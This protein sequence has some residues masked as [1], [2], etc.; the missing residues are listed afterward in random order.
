MRSGRAKEI[1]LKRSKTPRDALSQLSLSGCAS[2]LRLVARVAGR[3]RA[4]RF[5]PDDSFGFVRSTHRMLP[6][7]GAP[8]FDRLRNISSRRSFRVLVIT[9]VH[10]TLASRKSSLSWTLSLDEAVSI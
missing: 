6:A 3:W 4:S 2:V 8:E 9:A 1:V 10:V 5:E 7:A